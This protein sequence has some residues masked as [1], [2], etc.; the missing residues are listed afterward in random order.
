MSSDVKTGLTADEWFDRRRELAAQ[1][2]KLWAEYE[3]LLDNPTVSGSVEEMSAEINRRE[4]L[5]Q[6]YWR[7][8]ARMYVA[9]VNYL[10]AEYRLDPADVLNVEP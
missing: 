8:H 3:P 7:A 9:W 1:A 6:E 5:R 2:D 10:V 4:S